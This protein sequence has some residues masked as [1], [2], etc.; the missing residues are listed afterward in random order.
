MK[1]LV[2]RLTNG[3]NGNP[4]YCVKFNYMTNIN[5]KAF[6]KVKDGFNFSIYETVKDFLSKNVERFEESEL[7]VVYKKKDFHF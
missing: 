7:V 2:L 6:R 5:D 1:T 3:V 4:R